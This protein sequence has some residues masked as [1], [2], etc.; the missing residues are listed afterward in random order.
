MEDYLITI[1]KENTPQVISFYVA[2]DGEDNESKIFSKQILKDLVVTN[3]QQDWIFDMATLNGCTLNTEEFG[4]TKQN[5]TA[6]QSDVTGLHVFDAITR[7]IDTY[8][9]EECT[10]YFKEIVVLPEIEPAEKK[11]DKAPGM[12]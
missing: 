1:N 11:D 2:T 4:V 6:I 3:T 12:F 8:I 5:S 9:K 10:L 7:K